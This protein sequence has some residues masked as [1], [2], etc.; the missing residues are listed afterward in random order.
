[1]RQHVVVVFNNGQRAAVSTPTRLS[2]ITAASNWNKRDGSSL[3][4]LSRQMSPL[5]VVQH[6]GRMFRS[7]FDVSLISPQ[8]YK[9][10]NSDTE[11]YESRLAGMGSTD[12]GQFEGTHTHKHTQPSRWITLP[13]QTR[14]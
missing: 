2:D 14:T 3:G 1:M 6:C 5:T 8:A 12:K 7:I 4:L 13:A 9:T 10:I 11:R